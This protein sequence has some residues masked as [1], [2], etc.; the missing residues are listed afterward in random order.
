MFFE[1][2]S[3]RKQINITVNELPLEKFSSI[4]NQAIIKSIPMKMH[5]NQNVI[6]NI[7]S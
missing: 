3:K 5:A 1:F 2:T 6:S 4:H 7:H